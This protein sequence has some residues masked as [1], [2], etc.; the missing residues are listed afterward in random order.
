[1]T[2]SRN[3]SGSGGACICKCATWGANKRRR[4]VGPEPLWRHNGKVGRIEVEVA[5]SGR[6]LRSYMIS[7]ATWSMMGMARLRV[8]KCHL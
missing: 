2:V 7:Y 3:R 4:R 1:M 6:L 5:W 8:T